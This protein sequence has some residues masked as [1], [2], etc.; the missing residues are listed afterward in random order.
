MP[1]D[2]M[3]HFFHFDSIGYWEGWKFKLHISDL[4]YMDTDDHVCVHYTS[5]M[6][7]PAI[8]LLGQIC[9][10]SLLSYLLKNH[11]C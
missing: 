6:C 3:G 11:L 4:F 5:D 8:T 10:N 7:Y 2:Y 9:L 1:Q